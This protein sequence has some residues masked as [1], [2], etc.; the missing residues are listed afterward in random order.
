MKHPGAFPVFVTES[1]SKDARAAESALLT[2]RRCLC[3]TEA[4]SLSGGWVSSGGRA[5]KTLESASER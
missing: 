4:A 1:Q 5:A 3:F 2:Q